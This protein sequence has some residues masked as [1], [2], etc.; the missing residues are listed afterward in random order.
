VGTVDSSYLAAAAW[1]PDW[2]NGTLVY[3]GGCEGHGE[4]PNNYTWIYQG[5]SWSNVSGEGGSPPALAA[6]SM[7][8]DPTL[9][10][11]VLAGGYE[12]DGL[13]SAG[14]WLYAGGSWENITNSVGGF[15]VSPPTAYGAMAWD[16]ATQGMVYVGGCGYEQCIRPYDAQWTLGTGGTWQESSSYGNVTGEALAF[17]TAAQELIAFGGANA[18]LVQ[19][20]TTWALADGSWMNL[21][22]SSVSCFFECNLYPPGRVSASMTWDSLTDSILLV[23]GLNVNSEEYLNDSWTFSGSSWL[24]LRGGVAGGPTGETM[25]A[26]PVNS[27]GYAPV[28]VGGVGPAVGHTFVLETPANP[29]VSVIPAPADLGANVTVTTRVDAETGSG[30]WEELVSNYGNSQINRTVIYGITGSTPWSVTNSSLRYPSPAVVELEITVSD[31]FHLG[32]TT[33]YNM[34]ISSTP[35]VTLQGPPIPIETGFAVTFGSSVS[36]GTPPYFYLWTFGD[37]GAS[38]S[39]DPSHRY[40]APGSYNASLTVT[41]SGGGRASAVTTEVV[42]PGVRAHVSSNV[43]STDAGL[44]IDFRGSASNGTGPYSA[45]AWS[46]GDGS[47]GNGPSATHAFAVGTYRVVLN[48][49]D[50]LGFSN[51]SFL[52]IFVNPS[53]TTGGIT[54]TPTSLEVGTPATFDV[55][56]RGGTPPFAFDWS[57]G[58][59]GRALALSPTHSF[60]SAG[61]FEVSVVVTDSVGQRASSQEWVNVTSGAPSNDS[62]WASNLGLYVLVGYFVTGLAVMGVILRPRKRAPPSPI[63]LGRGFK[64]GTEVSVPRTGNTDE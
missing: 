4:C 31:F 40:S 20:N 50:H 24:P 10:G 21:T 52:T 45:Y 5:D 7:D 56:T 27:S 17:D 12:A 47:A 55:A 57:F 8:W 44:P 46:F 19:Q 64:A 15:S 18:A 32:T 33:S 61:T 3:F 62:N 25:G 37:G 48:V 1:D 63:R 6:M 53:P 35:L 49:T 30:P 14:T 43:T 60:A 42:V 22:S 54:A 41:D 11:I 9:E 36:S 38:S 59:G 58:D 2:A 39:A 29:Q 28:L 23:G 34:T 26:M 16:P 51:S 13:V